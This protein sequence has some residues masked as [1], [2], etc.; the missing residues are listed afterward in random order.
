MELLLVP[1]FERRSDMDIRIPGDS[2]LTWSSPQS[3][4]AVSKSFMPVNRR[5]AEHPL[6]QTCGVRQCWSIKL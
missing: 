6:S 4:A 5:A 2:L 3:T 1:C